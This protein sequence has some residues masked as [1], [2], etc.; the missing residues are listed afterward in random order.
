MLASRTHCGLSIVK[1][2]AGKVQSTLKLSAEGSDIVIDGVGISNSITV[3][4]SACEQRHHCELTKLYLQ[5]NHN[6]VD[7]VGVSNIITVSL[8][9]RACKQA[10]VLQNVGSVSNTTILSS[11]TCACKQDTSWS[12]HC[13]S[14]TEAL[15]SVLNMF[16]RGPDIVKH[17]LGVSTTTAVSA[18]FS[19]CRQTIACS[20]YCKASQ[21]HC[22]P[23][24]KILFTGPKIVIRC[25]YASDIITV[26]FPVVSSQ[27]HHHAYTIWHQQH[28]KLS[29][30]LTMFSKTV[31]V[32]AST[33]LENFKTF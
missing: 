33:A 12:V 3:S 19:A 27:A 21:G 22:S 28:S 24:S 2:S 4:V 9:A 8:P 26:S 32:S 31:T 25:M 14:S 15:Q 6:V 5:P 11:L 20:V 23:T 29:T 16:A 30:R 10:P 13:R 7:C 18:P 1:I 17:C